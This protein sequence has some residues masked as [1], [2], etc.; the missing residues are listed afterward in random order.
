MN[1]KSKPTEWK[2]SEKSKATC[3][4]KKPFE[5]STSQT[6]RYYVDVDSQ[7][8][9]WEP[10]TNLPVQRKRWMSSRVVCFYCPLKL[11]LTNLISHAT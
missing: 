8:D 9:M 10:I 7:D 5:A 1:E 11:V 2:A 6:T 3:T 4:S